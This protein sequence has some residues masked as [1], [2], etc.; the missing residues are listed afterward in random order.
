MINDSA[1]IHVGMYHGSGANPRA[2]TRA[3]RQF[4]FRVIAVRANDLQDLTHP[5]FDVLYLPG[6]W[7][8]FDDA[9]NKSIRAFVRKGGGCVGSCAGSY[10]VAG[11]IGLIKARLL[12]GNFRGRIYLE[13]QQGDHPILANVAQRC[14]RHNQ[15][16]WEP[17][18][19]THLGG[20]LIFPRRRDTILASY[21]AEGE[22]GALVADDLSKGRTVAI[23]SHPELALA[24][25]PAADHRALKHQILPQGDTKLLIRDAVSWAARRM[26]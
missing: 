19:V 11:P 17:V 23:A 14:T 9:I 5:L 8:R 25:L 1:T 13:P 26:G 10:L 24:S 3:L 15:R 16:Q 21:D 22:I 6:G 18:A 12:R 7:Y 2:L 4:G 20:P